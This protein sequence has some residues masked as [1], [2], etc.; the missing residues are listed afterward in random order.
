MADKLNLTTKAKSFGGYVV[1]GFIFFLLAGGV[2]SWYA[3]MVG[4]DSTNAL[5]VFTN[6][7]VTLQPLGILFGLGLF[8]LLGALALVFAIATIYIRKSVFNEKSRDVKFVKKRFL[9]PLAGIGIATFIILSVIGQIATGINPNVDLTNPT[10]L[11]EA[12]LQYNI[13]AVIGSF[14]LFALTGWAIVWVGSKQGAI[15]DVADKTRLNKI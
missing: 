11:Y 12:M 6:Q 1:G 15:S 10:T 4:F 5:Q 2:T 9:L 3:G 8:V 13:G 14:F 7:I